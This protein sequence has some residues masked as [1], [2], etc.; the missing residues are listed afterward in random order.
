MV[1][2]QLSMSVQYACKAEYLPARSTFRRW[3]HAALQNPAEVTLRIVD[4]VEGRQLNHQF[5][6]KNHATNVLTF[7]YSTGDFN[8]GAPIS[9]DIVL[10][11]PVVELEARRQGKTLRAHYAHLVVH[12]ILHLQGYEHETNRQAVIM[13]TQEAAILAKLGYGNPYTAA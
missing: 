7:T 12:G 5:R 4:E 13:E 11:A 8:N 10:C 6:G 2:P 1:L 3:A 9:G